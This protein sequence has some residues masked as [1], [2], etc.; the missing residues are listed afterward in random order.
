[1]AKI[2]CPNCLNEL[3]RIIVSIHTVMEYDEQEDGYLNPEGISDS[4]RTCPL[5]GY[6]LESS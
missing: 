5:C 2:R 6:S 3:D 1:M 4:E